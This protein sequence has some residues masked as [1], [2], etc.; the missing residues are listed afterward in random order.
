MVKNVFFFFV[1][2]I[3]RFLSRLFDSV[4]KM[5]L[6]ERYFKTYDVTA[7]LTNHCNTHIFIIGLLGLLFQQSLHVVTF[8]EVIRMSKHN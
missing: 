3:F 6:L 4:E 5:A 2:N 7:W 1:L 8:F